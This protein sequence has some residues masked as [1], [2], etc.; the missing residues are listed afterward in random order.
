[1]AIASEMVGRG[2]EWTGREARRRGAPARAMDSGI[3]TGGPPTN[4]SRG[5]ACKERA[6][7]ASARSLLQS[8]QWSRA[9]GEPRPRGLCRIHPRLSHEVD[10]EL[11]GEMTSS[12][13]AGSNLGQAY[14]TYYT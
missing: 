14:C 12:G 6:F 5:C 13:T 10:V 4:V 9:G 2:G 8:L 7:A 11:G 3:E 1:M